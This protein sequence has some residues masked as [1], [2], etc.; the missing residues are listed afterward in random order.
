[1]KVN[2][3]PYILCCIVVKVNLMLYISA[4]CVTLFA[5][6]RLP[7]PLSLLHFVWLLCQ[8]A[9]EVTEENLILD[10]DNKNGS[11]ERQEKGLM[12]TI[13]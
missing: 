12:I 11:G 1:M 13:R 4:F 3:M 9:A 6:M 7:K 2:V 5:E 10:K 8:T